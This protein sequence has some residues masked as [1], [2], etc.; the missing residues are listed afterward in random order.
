M[1]TLC[2][3]TRHGWLRAGRSAVAAADIVAT[4]AV[5]SRWVTRTRQQEMQQKT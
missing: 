2:A 1:H 3:C 5:V 4:C